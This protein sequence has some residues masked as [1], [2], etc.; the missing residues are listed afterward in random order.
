[1]F[2]HFTLSLSLLVVLSCTASA[3]DVVSIRT[4]AYKPILVSNT[5]TD[6]YAE[7]TAEFTRRPGGMS[8]SGYVSSPSYQS[9]G[10]PRFDRLGS[11][12]RPE[13]AI[14]STVTAPAKFL[15]REAGYVFLNLNGAKHECEIV[16]WNPTLVTF[17]MPTLDLDRKLGA[18]IEITR[19][20]GKVVRSYDIALVQ[21]QLY[22]HDGSD[23]EVKL[24][25]A[26][27]MPAEVAQNQNM[28][29]LE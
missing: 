20:D 16:S 18:S 19:P 11:K 26:G 1:M 4:V 22:V 10:S 29:S 8:G 5:T 17:Q 28:K 7:P 25:Q 27:L 24:A 21:P 12:V 6:S 15:G 3:D 9:S 23:L 14:G 2:R 13:V